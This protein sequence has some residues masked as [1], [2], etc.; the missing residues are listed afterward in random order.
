MFG[1]TLEYMLRNYTDNFEKS[2]GYITSDGSLHSYKKEYHPIILKDFENFSNTIQISTPIYPF[3]DA[4]LNEIIDKWPGQLNESKNIFI[5][6]ETLE[7]AELNLLFQFY[8]IV[9]GVLN[10]NFGIFGKD[11][12]KNFANWNSSYLHWLDMQKWELR[13]WF[14][15]YYPNWVNEWINVERDL[16]AI[17]KFLLINS[18]NILNDIDT[19]FTKIVKFSE[20]NANKNNDYYK[21]ISSWTLSQDYIIEEFK[22]IDNIVQ[23]TLKNLEFDWTSSRLCIISECIIQKRLRDNGYEI[24]CYNLNN[25]PTN[26][27]QLYNLLEKQ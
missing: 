21:F 13:E 16:S 10:D 3:P 2:H 1:S 19:E 18:I 20:L 22:L 11:N 17:N 27:E 4:K 5:R 7:D 24:K 8:K 15:I 23:K 6:A 25:F 9:K 14:S 26:S 12:N